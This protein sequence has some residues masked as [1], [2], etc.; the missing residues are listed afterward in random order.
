MRPAAAR[1][2]RQPTPGPLLTFLRWAAF[3][4]LLISPAARAQP[5]AQPA[6]G[7]ARIISARAGYDGLLPPERW[8]PVW[9][10]IQGGEQPQALLLSATYQQDATQTAVMVTPV[11]TTPGRT[12]TVPLLICPMHGLGRITVELS[13]GRRPSKVVFA[14]AP[15]DDE[16]PL[17]QPVKPGSLIV[18]AMGLRLPPT[19]ISGWNPKPGRNSATLAD[20]AAVAELKLADTG[21]TWACFD[22]LSVVVTRQ[23]ALDRLP[24]DTLDALSRWVTGGGRIVLIADSP[25]GAWRR[26]T[27]PGVRVADP[28]TVAPPSSLMRLLAPGE[29]TAPSLPARTLSVDGDAALRGW[30][31]S[32]QV[33]DGALIASGPFGGG[34]TVLAAFDPSLASATLSDSAVN[35]L[36][37][38]LLAAALPDRPPGAPAIG[39]YHYGWASSG[40][41]AVGAAALRATVDALCDVPP[42]PTWVYVLIVLF[43]TLLALLVGLADFIILGRFKARQRSWITAAA[44]IALFGAVAWALPNIVRREETSLGRATV[45]DALPA[46]APAHAPSARWRS[47]VTA[48][49][50]AT[51]T[52]APLTRTP[53][54]ANGDDLDGYWR[55]VSVLGEH[56]Y[57]RQS[58]QTAPTTELTILQRVSALDAAAAAAVPLPQGVG[59]RQWTLRTLHDVG[60]AHSVP[61]IAYAP[62]GRD[63]EYAVTGLPPGA[64]IRSAAVHTSRGWAALGHQPGPRPGTLLLTG[65]LTF[66]P[67]LGGWHKP[68]GRDSEADR[69]AAYYHNERTPADGRVYLQLDGARRRTAAF[70]ALAAGGNFAIVH[71]LVDGP[72]DVT[73]SIPH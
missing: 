8:S 51:S 69:Y 73:T 2:G 32:E 25:S 37:T 39:E 64:T 55:G 41:G 14:R 26:F 49:F 1:R 30:S 28:R 48:I 60:P 53:E 12:I 22:G 27:P 59:L 31:A 54:S 46:R 42:V 19:V 43:S 63:G 10:T 24:D 61:A 44:W 68:A 5:P 29:V 66:G 4:L 9:V 17:D 45:V 71:L 35:P 18:G 52:S 6:A 72:G 23:S 58:S 34:I 7:D 67:E 33:P 70:N 36:W 65:G 21:E 15:R 11:T 56:G 62:E 16:L 13:G 20:H 50:A 40:D 3:L 57:S 38:S 47:G